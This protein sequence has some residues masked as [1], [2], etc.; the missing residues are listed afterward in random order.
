MLSTPI[1]IWSTR[2]LDD[3]N[4]WFER[5]DARPKTQEAL[6]LPEPRTSAFGK[7]D[8]ESA[9]QKNAANFKE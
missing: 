4:A 7:G 3:L 6:L 9:A 2:P 1:P 5:L 8:I